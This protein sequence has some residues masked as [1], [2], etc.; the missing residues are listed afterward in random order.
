[1]AFHPWNYYYPIDGLG[2]DTKLDRFKLTKKNKKQNNTFRG[3]PR[4]EEESRSIFED[5]Y[6]FLKIYKSLTC[7]SLRL[8]PIYI[9]G[10]YLKDL[11]SRN[12]SGLTS[13]FFASYSQAHMDQAWY[14]GMFSTQF[15][16]LASLI[17]IHVWCS[18]V[19]SMHQSEECYHVS[20]WNWFSSGILA[21]VGHR[22]RPKSLVKNY[23]LYNKKSNHNNSI[24]SIFD[25]LLPW[26]K[27]CHPSWGSNPRHFH[28]FVDE[29][30]MSW[31][32]WSS[33]ALEWAN[34]FD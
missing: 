14:P 27:V 21:P 18:A 29:D 33:I 1:M 6:Q 3:E 19:S 8:G 28:G 16:F 26:P 22:K 9:Y 25:L 4:T 34:K 15:I 11:C 12:L 31:I 10:L 7:T 13:L 5:G 32:K 20:P 24:S 23:V 30:G 17:W 2:G